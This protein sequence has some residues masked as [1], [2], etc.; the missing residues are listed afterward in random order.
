[1]AKNRIIGHINYSKGLRLKNPSEKDSEKEIVAFNQELETVDLALLADHIKEHG[2]SFS[3]G[4]IYGVLTDMVECITEL[5]RGGYGVLIDGLG[6]FGVSLQSDGVDAD[7]VEDFTA[8]NITGVNLTFR[9]A[10][11]IKSALNTNMEFEYVGTRIAQA[12]AK[13][14][15][16]ENLSQGISATTSNGS[17]S[18]NGSSGGS[19]S[20]DPGDVTP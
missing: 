17:G 20:G 15:E 10:D 18:G 16:Q 2:S 4:T 13:K 11:E 7:E 8:S 6:K 9:G 14:T 19:G 12:A 1:M 3:K 5:L